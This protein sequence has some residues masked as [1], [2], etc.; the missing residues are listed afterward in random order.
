VRLRSRI[1][2]PKPRL[3]LPNNLLL[4]SPTITP[5]TITQAMITPTTMA[6]AKLLTLATTRRTTTRMMERR[7][8]LLV[9]RTRISN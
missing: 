8:M 3:Q 5:D 1:S 6:R 2:T 7:S 4:P 9:L